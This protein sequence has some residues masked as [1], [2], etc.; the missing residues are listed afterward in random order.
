MIRQARFSDSMKFFKRDFCKRW[1]VTEYKDINA[2]CYFVGIY[3]MEDVN[4]I[5]DHKGFKV[6]WNPGRVRPF[7]T[8]IN[9]DNLIVH[10]QTDVIDHSL[11]EGKYKIKQCRFEIKDYSLFKPN[12][13]GD[14]IYCYLGN[15]GSKHKYRY[16][17][18]EKL[19]KLTKYKI[20]VGMLG[21][22]IEQLKTD[23]YDNCFVYFKSAL[24]GGGTTSEELALMG[25]N[26][27]NGLK[28][29]YYK[30][31]DSIE[32]ACEL[33]EEEAKNIGKVVGSVLSE[34]HFDTGEEW[35]QVKFW[36]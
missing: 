34:D 35:K 22:T 27:I 11:I 26:T 2:P 13:L 8:L 9:P 15:E 12:K 5:N 31:Y 1:N 14:C 24:V 7:F 23:M 28:V 33:I 36:L 29:D 25:R 3:N 32:H 6:V 17:E 30:S 19:R 20:I 18:V 21:R 10:K 4:A 16:E